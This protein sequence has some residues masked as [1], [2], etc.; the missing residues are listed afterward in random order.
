M[1]TPANLTQEENKLLAAF[2]VL[3]ELSEHELPVVRFN[4]RKAKHEL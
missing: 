1:M 4:C 3:E 2:R